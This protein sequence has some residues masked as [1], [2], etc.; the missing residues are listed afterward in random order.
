MNDQ[1]TTFDNFPERA[2]LW[3][4]VGGVGGLRG[5]Q[6]VLCALLGPAGE[7]VFGFALEDI[8]QAIERERRQRELQE[9]LARVRAALQSFTSAP[10]PNIAQP[11]QLLPV[12]Q[13][14]QSPGAIL[15]D[16]KTLETAKD[17]K[18]LD[19]V[20][21]PAIVLVL[22]KRGSGKSALGYRLL[23]LF[24]YSLTPYV[25]G[26][27]AEGQKLLPEWIG[28]AQGLE[29]IPRKS[30]VLADEAY[31]RYHSRESLSATSK[32]MSHC[33]NLSRQRD[34][35][36]IFI[37]QEARQVDRNIA[38]SANV[39]IFKDL[40]MLQPEFD[41]PEFNRLA[42]QARDALMSIKGDKR[43]WS[44]VYSPDSDFAGLLENSMPTFWSKGLSHVFAAGKEPSMA[45]APRRLTSAERIQQARE[46]H[47]Q[48][49]S[50]SSIARI[51]NVSKGTAYNY[52]RGYPNKS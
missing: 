47:K 27:P 40:G 50:Y 3:A 23:E 17:S 39:V 45:K 41:R 2:A 6:L 42:S 52:V 48:K 35:T 19:I 20:V 24:K 13:P 25:L 5:I 7:K 29:D 10:S 36:I 46:L 33:L 49:L 18:W 28:M 14:A 26:V 30:I 34:Q 21:H 1:Q 32:E 38:S 9:G 31:L 8:V 51:L 44:Y 4:L 22:G 12:L 37:T 11:T 16:K 15:P 43:R